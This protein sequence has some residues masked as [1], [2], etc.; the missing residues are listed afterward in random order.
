MKED[1]TTLRRAC[2]PRSRPHT[3]SRSF[4]AVTLCLV[5]GT[6]LMTGCMLGPAVG[7]LTAVTEASV[8]VSA[9]E[10]A[11]RFVH[12]GVSIVVQNETEVY[13]GPGEECSRLGRLNK[14]VEVQLVASR[15]DWLMCSSDLFGKGWIHASSALG[16]SPQD[17]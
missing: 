12:K 4:V 15:G 1:E 11:A 7:V 10:H 2:F 3:Q 13:T 5:L 6:S 16:I 9:V 17:L 8:L 14:G